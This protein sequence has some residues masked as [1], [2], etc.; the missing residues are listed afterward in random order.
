LRGARRDR[1]RGSR[2]ARAAEGGPAQPTRPPP[3][4]GARGQAAG[5]PLPLRG[6]PGAGRP[7]ARAPAARG[8]EGRMIRVWRIPFSTNVERVAL[9]LGHKGLA[10]E[11][12]DG[13]PPH[14]TPVREVS[15]QDLVPVLEEDGRIL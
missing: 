1:A 15:G 2:G 7:L 8:A 5:R 11:W 13:D 9:A 3:G 14:P 12:G 6:P 4:R 10:V